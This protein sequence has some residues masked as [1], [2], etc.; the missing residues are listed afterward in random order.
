[1]RQNRILIRNL[2]NYRV[3]SDAPWKWRELDSG[4]KR[5][6]RSAIKRH[7]ENAGLIPRVP[8]DPETRFADFSSV[9]IRSERLPENLWGSTDRVQ[10]NYLDDLIGGRPQGTTWHHHQNS[11]RMELVPFGVHNI[12]NHAGGRT[13]W[14][15]GNR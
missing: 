7:A 4:I 8:V 15:T 14:A 10:F 1:M 12:T 5:S 2:C 13:T 3:N 11:G 6:E 9:V